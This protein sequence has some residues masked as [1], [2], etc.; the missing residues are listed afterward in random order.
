MTHPETFL[1]PVYRGTLYVH[2]ERGLHWSVVEH[3]VLVA[4]CKRPF[5]TL[6]LTSYANLPQNV[7]VEVVMRLMRA[8]WVETTTDDTG[9]RFKAS[10]AGDRESKK[11]SLTPIVRHITKNLHFAVDRVTG[12]VMG[13][14]TL[15]LRHARDLIELRRRCR[16][17]PLSMSDGEPLGNLELIHRLSTTPGIVYSDEKIV[18]CDPYRSNIEPDWYLTLTR[19]GNVLEG[20][21]S[22]AAPQLSVGIKRVLERLSVRAPLSSEELSFE[23]S[24]E[25]V[26]QPHPVD[27]CDSDLLLGGPAHRDAL[28]SALVNARKRVI[29]HS[30]FLSTQGLKRQIGA[31]KTAMANGVTVDLLW[32]RSDDG[33]HTEVFEE[34]EALLQKAGLHGAV[35]LSSFQTRSHSK[36]I[37]ADDGEGQYFAIIGSCNW[38][39][40]PFQSYEASVR[41]R[42]SVLTAES[43]AFIEK[44]LPLD[45]DTGGLKQELVTLGL[46]LAR[47]PSPLRLT[48]ATTAIVL[49]QGSHQRMVG[50][51]RDTA[52]QR[53]FVASNKAGN[54]IETQILAPLDSAARQSDPPE[55]CVYYQNERVGSA[56]EPQVL[57]ELKSRYERIGIQTVE[58]AHAK[59]LCWDSNHAVVTSLNWLSKDASFNNFVGECGVYLDSPG[60]AE[61][62]RVAYLAER[63]R[64]QRRKDKKNQ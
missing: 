57:E 52:R 39:S 1:L 43:L 46:E 19:I 56:L 12:T 29:V 47:A 53:I 27:I 17:L 58:H 24:A 64:P 18:G 13:L 31:L 7:V 32:D 28:H 59:L 60:I 45:V 38:L 10:A 16:T 5:S 62:L 30:T 37:I 35:R 48:T 40:S 6:E 20:L 9:T 25:P 8:G 2:L 54:V 42:S 3:L 44:M 49:S 33:K 34:C 23:Y 11:D 26:H 36:L 21:P 61:R 55:V 15:K 50:R 14:D 63:R 22:A 51:A 41:L 4:L